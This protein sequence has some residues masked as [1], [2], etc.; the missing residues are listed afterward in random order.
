MAPRPMSRRPFDPYT[1][2]RALRVAGYGQAIDAAIVASDKY[3]LAHLGAADCSAKSDALETQ[4]M[5]QQIG[6]IVV[7]AMC[8]ETCMAAPPWMI[9]G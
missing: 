2:R 4:V 1:L 6:R 8:D 7:A 9:D 5:L 3:S